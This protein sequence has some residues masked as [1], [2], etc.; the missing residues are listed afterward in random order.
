MIAFESPRAIARPTADQ[1]GSGFWERD[2]LN[3]KYAKWRFFDHDLI[4]SL[5]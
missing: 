2:G 4:T 3:L 5:A 1:G